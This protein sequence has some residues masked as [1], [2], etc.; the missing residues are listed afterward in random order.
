MKE[1]DILESVSNIS[2]YLSQEAQHFLDMPFSQEEITTVV[3]EM[4]KLKASGLDSFQVGFYK[5]YWSIIGEYILKFA[6][7]FF[8]DPLLSKRLTKPS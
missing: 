1:D 8:K 2:R 6:N 7:K 3:F 5:K 4:G